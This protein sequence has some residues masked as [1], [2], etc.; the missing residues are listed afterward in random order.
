MWQSAQAREAIDEVCE[1]FGWQ[2]MHLASKEDA[3]LFKG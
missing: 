2:E 1:T 3:T